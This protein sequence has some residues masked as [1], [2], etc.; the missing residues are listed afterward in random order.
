MTHAGGD[1]KWIVGYYTVFII[2]NLEFYVCL[3][4]N[5]KLKYMS[6]KFALV[7]YPL[8]L[9]SAP[10]SQ[11]R[12][13]FLTPFGLNFTISVIYPTSIPGLSR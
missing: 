4:S 11:R 3:F 8:Q 12:L 1:V 9:S 6:I 10:E 2:Y 5:T 7:N 13:T